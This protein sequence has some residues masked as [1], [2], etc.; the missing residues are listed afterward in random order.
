MT[1]ITFE[2][3]AE[4]GQPARIIDIRSR[5]GF[6]RGS[7]PGAEN[8][9]LE[10]FDADAFSTEEPIFLLC[11]TGVKSLE[12]AEDLTDEGFQAYSIRGGYRRF[13]QMELQRL[14]NDDQKVKERQHRAEHSSIITTYR[15]ELWT[16]FHKALRE[17][18]LIQDGDKIAVC[19]SGGK[20]SMLMAKLF[21]E[22]HAHGRKNFEV[23]YLVM[24]PGYNDLNYRA[25]VENAKL[26]GIP[27]EV[28]KTEI[29][30]IV[31]NQGGSPCY[32]KKYPD[33]I[34][35]NEM[36]ELIHP[37]YLTQHL[38]IVLE[39]NNLRKIRFHDLRHS[40]ASL[41]YANGVSLKEIQEWLGH[42][43]ISTTSNI[44]THLTFESKVA[45]ANAI[46]NIFPQNA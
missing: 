35:V 39:K 25:V 3:L 6:A 29:F 26:L 42:S 12:L 32:S 7:Y 21:Q 17:Y 40:C 18:Q 38:P 46:L 31:A 1:E 15:K 20:D 33:Y 28:F 11:H 14:A 30:D 27:I 9:P 36:G 19:I 45:S 13:L 22:L 10:E 4:R 41:L 2:A 23:V 34:Y 24:N 44:Y 8:I 37:N 43:D 16:A 5:D